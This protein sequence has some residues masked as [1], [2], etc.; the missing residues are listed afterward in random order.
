MEEGLRNDEFEELDEIDT[1]AVGFAEEVEEAYNDE[2]EKDDEERG[3]DEVRDRSS[4][5][6]FFNITQGSM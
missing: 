6:C 3:V 2:L 1:V 4:R 5:Y